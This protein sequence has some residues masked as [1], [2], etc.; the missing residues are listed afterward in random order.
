MGVGLFCTDTEIANYVHL[1]KSQL[2][3]QK[4]GFGP[5]IENCLTHSFE[6]NIKS[7]SY[8]QPIQQ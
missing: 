3:R 2:L 8:M 6:Y 7:N 5:L 4:T 1:F